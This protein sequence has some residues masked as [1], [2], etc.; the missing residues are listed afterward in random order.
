MYVSRVVEIVHVSH[1]DENGGCVRV[2]VNVRCLICVFVWQSMSNYSRV[3]SVDLTLRWSLSVSL[4][5]LS[6]LSNEPLLMAIDVARLL[7]LWYV[8]IEPSAAP[9]QHSYK[10]AKKTEKKNINKLTKM[11]R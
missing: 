4:A 2:Y 9:E 10:M 7:K 11:V 6:L 1:W 3:I 8:R 5:L